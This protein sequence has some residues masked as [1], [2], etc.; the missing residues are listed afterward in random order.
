MC[1]SC[2]NWS[3]RRWKRMRAAISMPASES[4]SRAACDVQ[5]V[6]LEGVENSR[7]VVVD[8]NLPSVQLVQSLLSRAG[9]HPVRA[10]TDPVVLLESY[11]ELAPDLILLDLHMPGVDGYTVLTELRRRATAPELP[12]L[13]LT[14]DMTREA[15]HR[16]LRLGA[17]DFLT[18]PLEA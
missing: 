18:K 6:S 9:L 4:P 16:A 10:I 7:V 12:V 13:V 1:T 3:T 15:T 11:D 8:D 17:N 14:A 2:S 5:P